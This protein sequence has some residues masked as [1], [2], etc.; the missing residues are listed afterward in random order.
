MT[1]ETVGKKAFELLSK[2]LEAISPIDIQKEAEKK[3]LKEL[4]DIIAKHKNYADKYYIQMI[5]RKHRTIPNA[6]HVQ[7]FV[8][9]SEPVPYYDMSLWSYDNKKEEL[10]YHW[11]I[12]DEETCQYLLVNEHELKGDE[13]AL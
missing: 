9:K 11:T 2:P 1:T 3:L 4:E 13:K 7:T 12:P 6:M 5:F 10:L 8:R